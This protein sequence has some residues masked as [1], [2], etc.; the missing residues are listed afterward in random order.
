MPS[1]KAYQALL[2]KGLP[3][4]EGD[5]GP[6][7]LY[8]TLADKEDL[9]SLYQVLNLVNDRNNHPAVITAFSVTANPDFEKLIS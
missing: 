6:Y 9:T 5:S 4:S 3:V 8:D 2:E 1:E 7:N